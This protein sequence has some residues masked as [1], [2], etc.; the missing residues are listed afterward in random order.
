MPPGFEFENRDKVRR[1]NQGFVLGPFRGGE[2]AFVCPLTEHFDP[3][4]HRRIDPEGNQTPG[5]LRV[6]AKAERLQ[7]SVKPGCRIHALTLTRE[8]GVYGSYRLRGT[9]TDSGA[10]ANEQAGSA[11]QRLALQDW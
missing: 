1:V 2:V 6:E 7:K 5:R 4:L 9:L 10:A 3:C 11:S 8:T